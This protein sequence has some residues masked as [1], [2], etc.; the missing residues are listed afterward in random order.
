M[1]TV[2]VG[3]DYPIADKI[4]HDM[5]R[6]PEEL[7]K[8]LRPK[9][10]NAAAVVANEAKARAAW[11]SRIPATIRVQT[12]FRFDREGVFVIAGGKSTPHARLYESVGQ[13]AYFRHP[14]FGNRNRW[15]SQATRPFLFPAARA[16]EAET[17]VAIYVALGEAAEAIGFGG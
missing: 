7:R 5:Q 1:T 2:N 3:L 17:H 10:R 11:S 15:Y 14:L 8:A 12:S 13:R 16:H 9:L 4:Q 6:L